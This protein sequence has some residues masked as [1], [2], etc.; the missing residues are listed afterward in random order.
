MFWCDWLVCCSCHGFH[1]CHGPLL[2]SS[3]ATRAEIIAV[4]HTSREVN[5]PII[6]G[7]ATA[8]RFQRIMKFAQ[9]LMAFGRHEW[10]SWRGLLPHAF[11]NRVC[12]MHTYP[13]THT[14]ERTSS[15]DFWLREGGPMMETWGKTRNSLKGGERERTKTERREKRREEGAKLPKPPSVN[16]IPSMSCFGL[17]SRRQVAG[18]LQTWRRRLST[19]AASQCCLDEAHRGSCL[20]GKGLDAHILVATSRRASLIRLV[21]DIWKKDC[22]DFP[23]QSQTSLI[24]DLALES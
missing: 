14:H 19:S 9:S 1:F 17:A 6:T 24:C 15:L 20:K 5:V 21:A 13:P 12:D 7:G 11:S 18:V 3:K 10:G 4:I 2:D 8:N 22:W 16:V 23:V